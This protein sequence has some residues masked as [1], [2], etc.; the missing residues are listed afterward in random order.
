MNILKAT[1][2]S[3]FAAAV[4][5]AAFVAISNAAPA[6]MGSPETAAFTGDTAKGEDVFNGT[7]IACHG[8]NGKGAV[9]GAPDFTKKGG[10][11]SQADSVL[12]DHMVNGFQ[13]EG[14]LLEMPPLGGNPDLTEE[15]MENALAYLRKT[16][17]Q[18]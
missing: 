3:I 12:L 10:V 13:S 1:A 8:K 18:E 6:Q 2:I 7:C 17:A 5:S 15:D 9:P 11:L 16:F 14:A 4:S